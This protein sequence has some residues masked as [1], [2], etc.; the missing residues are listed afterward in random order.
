MNY[1]IE[2]N[3]DITQDD[4][5]AVD[6]LEQAADIPLAKKAARSA[7]VAES[8]VIA[9][10]VALVL[11]FR[12]FFAFELIYFLG[13]F[14]LLFAANFALNYFRGIDR[15]FKLNM[16]NLL[17]N[18][19]TGTIYTPESGLAFFWEDRR[20]Y[21]TNEQRR[22]F[23]YDKVQHIKE[24]RHLFIF[25]MK[26]A[27][28]KGLRGFAW[29]VL[30]KRNLTPRQEEEFRTLCRMIIEKYSLKPWTDFALFD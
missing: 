27:K 20:E 23:T 25:I 30:P 12:D 3:L 5:I 22:Y 18:S 11:V 15:E 26:R 29:M 17:K 1:P 21:L 24:T 2:V 9:V 13:G 4:F 19:R 14:W 8:V 16:T 7:F 10:G 6:I 28:D